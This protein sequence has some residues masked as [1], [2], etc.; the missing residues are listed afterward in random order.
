MFSL[1][2]ENHTNFTEVQ[3]QNKTL[4]AVKS[5]FHLKIENFVAASARTFANLLT[6]YPSGSW[7]NLTYTV[8]ATPDRLV[9]YYLT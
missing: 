7:I 3:H 5:D 4:T 1:F 9:Q 2:Y 8:H 6:G